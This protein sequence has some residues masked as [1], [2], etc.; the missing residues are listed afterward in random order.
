[1]INIK[2]DSRKIKPGDIFVALKGISSNGSDYINSAIENGASKLIVEVDGDYEIPYEVV[3]DSREYL[4]KY[5]VD[6]Y[7]KYLEEMTIVGIT[8]TN[9]KTT[10]AYLLY[11]SL[12]RLGRK[13]AYIGTIG[14]YMDSKVC[15]LPNTNPDVADIY[16]MIITAYDNGY[17]YIVMEVSSH[18]LSLGRLEGIKFD[19]ALFTNLTQ[20]H[21]DY[22]KTMGNYALAK[23]SL[24]KKLKDNGKAI[25][26]FDDKYKEYFLLEENDNITYG[27]DG[28]DY[29]VTNY[30]MNQGGTKFIYNYN[31]NDYKVI[32]PLLGKYNIYNT[33]LVI[34]TLNQMGF[35]LSD[36]NNIML[37]LK[38]PAGRMDMIKYGDSVIVIDYAHTPDA[39]EKIIKTV[40]EV[41]KGNIYTVFGCTGDRDRTKR[42]I[43]MNIVT[44]LSKYVIVTNDDPHNEDPNQIVNDMLEG[45][46]VNNYEVCLDRK[47]AI[48]KGIN[49]LNENDSLL[50]LGKGHEEVMIIKDNKRVPFNDK[51]VVL[52]YLESITERIN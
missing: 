22:H 28:G 16:D 21:L 11:E 47:Q 23:Q 18:G 29:K 39:V 26:N 5:L 19:Y 30:D 8:G 2:S 25:I 37:K 20:D 31:N 46:E 41:T 35:G 42:P 1:M 45:I 9:G 4:N 51:K 13:C 33:L 49:L 48:I 43:M 44:S 15:N 12:N 38:S 50:I 10:S 17:R 27:F 52:E 32:T 34:S 7:S 6:N 40:S 3:N 36:I 24:F 14:F